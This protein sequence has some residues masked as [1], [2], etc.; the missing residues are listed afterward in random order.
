M[1]CAAM[2]DSG[3]GRHIQPSHR[4]IHPVKR[5]EPGSRLSKAVVA[6][7]FAYISGLTAR[8]KVQ[9]VAAH[10][11]TP[12][13]DR[14]LPRRRRHRQKPAR[15]VQHLAGRHRHLRHHERRREAG[16]DRDKNP[17]ARATVELRLG[18]QGNLVD[19]RHRARTRRLS[20]RKARL[21][22]WALPAR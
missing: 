7:G 2:A 3:S 11:T 18:G 22:G 1:A 14:R 20:D 5:I 10:M 13:P 16:L 12:G 4:S 6:N 21:L 15:H 8:E 17:P 19:Q 9:D